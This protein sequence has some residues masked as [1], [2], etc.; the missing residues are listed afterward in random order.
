M[1]DDYAR[2]LWALSLRIH[3]WGWHKSVSDGEDSSEI[4]DDFVY[5]ILGGKTGHGEIDNSMTPFT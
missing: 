3:V 5:V 1:E 4:M 2:F